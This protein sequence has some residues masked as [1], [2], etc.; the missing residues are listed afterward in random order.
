MNFEQQANAEEEEH[1]A[2]ISTLKKQLHD[3]MERAEKAET[4]VITVSE[5]QVR[6]MSRANALEQK[7]T[8]LLFSWQHILNYTCFLS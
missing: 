6:L 1:K 8:S 7:A 5:S 4:K 3:I 2:T